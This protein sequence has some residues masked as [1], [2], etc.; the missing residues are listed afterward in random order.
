MPDELVKS[1]FDPH[2]ESTFEIHPQTGEAVEVTLVEITDH[3]N[4]QI[5][6]FS[7]IFRAPQKTQ[8]P[9]SIYKLTHAKMGD[10]DL[11]LVPIIY[12]NADA[13][14]YEAVFSRLIEK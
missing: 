7:V 1:S 6:G 14:Y 9:Q 2:L 3:S 13:M 5:N 4:E 10:L 12:G 11:F 8:L